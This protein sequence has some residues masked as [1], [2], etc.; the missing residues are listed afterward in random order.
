LIRF[1]LIRENASVVKA[2]L[3]ATSRGFKF[4]AE[5]PDEAADLLVNEVPDID[6]RLAKAS[7]QFLSQVH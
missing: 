7:Q 5:H 3:E 4:A 1:D 2:F 6:V